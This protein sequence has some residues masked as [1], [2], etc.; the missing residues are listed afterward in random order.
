MDARSFPPLG[1]KD[2]TEHGRAD[3]SRARQSTASAQ[4]FRTCLGI[5]RLYRGIDPE[6][7]ETVSARAV[8]IGALT[9]KSVASILAHKL[10]KPSAS[11]RSAAM[12]FDHQNL[13]GPRYFN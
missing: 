10:D 11:S 9:Y 13:R 12:L 7:A 5:L 1:R 4:G 8:A 3:R 6:R 2:R